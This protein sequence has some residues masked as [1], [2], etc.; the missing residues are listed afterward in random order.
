MVLGVGHGS[1]LD[2]RYYRHCTYL[3]CRG[4][5]HQAQ[6]V[7]RQKGRGV[8]TYRIERGIPIPTSIGAVRYPF[9]KMKIGDS[10]VAEE[11][12][13]QAAYNYG[14]RHGKQFTVRKINSRGEIRIWRV[15]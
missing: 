11:P 1:A 9:A 14:G 3:Y 12:A 15:A 6:Q 7:G 13:R 4:L 2:R 10:F 5:W 8:S